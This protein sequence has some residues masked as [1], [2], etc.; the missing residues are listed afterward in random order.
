LRH[1]SLF[2]SIVAL[3]LV[4][5]FWKILALV[6]LPAVSG[7]SHCFVLVPLTNTV[8]LLGAPMLPTWWVKISTYLHLKL[9]R[10]MQ[11]ILRIV[12]RIVQN[13]NELLLFI[14]II[15][16]TVITLVTTL[17]SINNIIIIIDVI[18]IITSIIRL[19]CIIL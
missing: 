15:S 16:I 3:N 9:F 18:H 7:N 6:F 2:R 13:R 17:F 11:F 10:C 14:V 19:V 1:F 8:L 4:L 12:N 5:P